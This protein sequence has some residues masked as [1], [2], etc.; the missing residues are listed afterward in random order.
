MKTNR[1]SA[2]PLKKTHE[3]AVAYQHTTAEQDLRRSVMACLLW[4]GEFYES[5]VEIA[6]R[7][8]DLAG[9]VPPTTL[10]AIAVEARNVAKIRH[11]PL[12][13]LA[14]L[15]RTGSGNGIVSRTFPAV[16][17]RADELAEFMAIY[18]RVNGVAPSAVK[19]KLSV[20]ARKGLALA[21]RN[22]DAYQLAKY[23]REAAIQLRD[24]AFLTHVRM[25]DGEHGRLLANLVNRSFFPETTKSAGF[26][27]RRELGL[28]GETKP[29]LE[30]PDT[31]EVQLSGGADKRET[32]ERLIREGR[33]GYLALLR[34]LRNM[35]QAGC[36][37]K[38]VRDAIVA[39][40]GAAFVLPFRYT[41]AARACPQFEPAI[42]QALSEAIGELPQLTGRTIVL[43]DVSGSMDAKLSAKSDLT[44][45]DAAATLAS[46][47]NGDVRVFSFSNSVIEVP[48][49][50]GMAG[51][52]AIQSSQ[53]H[54]GTALY[55]AVAQTV[56]LPHDRMIV[57]SDEQ[58]GE[59]QQ[60]RMPAPRAG[61]RG[62]VI[63]V[64]SNRNGVGYGPWNHI[65]GFS[66]NVIRW[67]YE[68]ERAGV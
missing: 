40:K 45:M 53:L 56:L 66:E 12:L 58:A 47:I 61:A 36:D 54:S 44:R 11:A 51:V 28:D 48:P 19:R 30:A 32:F 1:R 42:D 52:D 43:V 18:A 3:G 41:A 21:F 2:A 29:K 63:N 8:G 33:L 59:F 26:P 34:N 27:V 35:A 38:L 23:D 9:T 57:I 64:A 14:H 24:V 68:V 15:C 16:I 4:E 7:I 37:E 6:K 25:R 22:F 13:L 31:W 50:R 39:R 10:A 5:G 62:Y 20:Q 49:R 65:D 46:I 60:R 55:D 17:K 67:I